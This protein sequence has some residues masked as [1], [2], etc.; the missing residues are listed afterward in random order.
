MIFN[1]L[2]LFLSGSIFV[3][4]WRNREKDREEA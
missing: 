1:T 4:K 3:M 2:S